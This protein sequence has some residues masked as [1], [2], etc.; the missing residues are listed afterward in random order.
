MKKGQPIEGV[1]LEE[2]RVIK[3]AVSVAC[4][5]HRRLPDRLVHP[6]GDR[7]GRDRRRFDRPLAGRQQRSRPSMG[8]RRRPSREAVHVLQ[9]LPGQRNEESDGLLRRVPLPE[10]R[11]DDRRR[12]V[13][14]PR[15]RRDGDADRRGDV[16]MSDINA[17]FTAV[18]IALRKRMWLLALAAI[19]AAALALIGLAAV[20]ARRRRAG[21]VRRK[22][23]SGLRRRRTPTSCTARSAPRPIAACPTGCGRRCPAS[24]RRSSKAA[25][26][27]RLSGFNIKRMPTESRSTCRSA[28]RAA[29]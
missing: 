12:H 1:N 8:R 24:S 27:I 28:F 10:P 15:S 23:D 13:G 11:G 3:K 26:T 7:F 19:L 20:V 2:A 4:H 5:L 21:Q 9:P 18:Q 25:T 14:L 6:R 22:R 29:R 17:P 16:A